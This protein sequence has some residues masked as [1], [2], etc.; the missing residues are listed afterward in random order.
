MRDKGEPE[1]IRTYRGAEDV[2]WEGGGTPEMFEKL[3]Y[4]VV[5]T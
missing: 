1:G 2:A 4:R 5:V 3:V